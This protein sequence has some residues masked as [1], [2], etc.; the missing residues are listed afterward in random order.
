MSEIVDDLLANLDIV[1]I[2]SRYVSLKRAGVNF[3][4]LCP[5]HNEKTPSF[6]VSPQKQ[7]FKCFGCGKGWDVI[8]FM[9]EIERIDF[10]DAAKILA[11]D[12][13]IDLEKYT[14]NM[15]RSKQLSK[16]YWEEKEMLK[17][18]HKYAQQFFS[19]Q[20]K[21][22]QVA[23]EYLSQKRHIQDNVIEVFQIAYAPDS[24]YDLIQYL[25]NKWFTQEDIVKS[26]LAKEK[27]GEIFSFF[28][29]RIMFPIRDTMGNIVAFSGRVL[30][31][32]DKPK[33]LN[34][35]EHAAFEKS[36]ILYGLDIA[37]Q[38]IKTYD[39]LIVVEGQMDVIGLYR[40][41]F[42]VG[43]ATSWTAITT[44]HM[45]IMKRYTK[46]IYFLFDNDNAGNTATVR[47]L[48][49]AYQMGMFPK[50]ISLPSQ[51][52]D[53]DDIANLPYAKKVFQQCFDD[54]RD[55]FSVFLERLKK[56]FDLTSP[57]E[58]QKFLSEVFS[59]VVAISDIAIQD[60]YLQI[61][62]ENIMIRYE[63]LTAQY[64]KYMTQDGKLQ[65]RQQQNQQKR[66][67][68]R[69]TLN[70][71]DLFYALLY[72]GFINKYVISEDLSK[73]LEIFT[74]YTVS[75]FFVHREEGNF[76]KVEK[77]EWEQLQLWWE[78]NLEGVDQ[79]MQYQK[80][81][82]LIIP[83]IQKYIKILLADKTISREEIKKILQLRAKLGK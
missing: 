37:K 56:V 6:V 39:A 3:S 22:N 25:K 9:K 57:V 17:L 15:Q 26:S 30:K 75:W 70:R 11:K 31:S 55:G 49:I 43:V 21:K 41:W 8:T 83:I 2:V 1:D 19:E 69:F 23:L 71:E 33:Y 68:E 73:L 46:N 50:I 53:V 36:K 65:I 32:E 7:I 40:V 5:F 63:I 66:K 12:A 35:A 62:A 82:Q 81:L 29:N 42:P 48:K 61:V 64:K 80:I 34:S 77:E 44:N 16:E 58:K 38:H 79:E 10:R 74:E 24:Y 4:G 18:I 27:N 13:H 52:K 67:G 51:C 20:L 45:A 76:S 60:H 28:R 47:A 78:K 59:V 72:N 14:N 54:A